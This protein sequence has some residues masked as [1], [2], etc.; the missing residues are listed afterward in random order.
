MDLICMQD[1]VTDSDHIMSKHEEKKCPRCGN[2]FECK[3]GTIALCQCS[4]V[5][6]NDEQRSYIAQKYAEC[7][8]R[9]CLVY[10]SEEL[11]LFKERYI[12][13]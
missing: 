11:N 3:V 13:K 6:L 9:D 4:G 1:F 5:A 7:L 10:L 8:C 2:A 12:F